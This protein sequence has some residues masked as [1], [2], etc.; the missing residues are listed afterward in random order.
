M[1]SGFGRIE[2][3][4]AKHSSK[5]FAKLQFHKSQKTFPLYDRKGKASG[6]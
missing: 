6:F 5:G 2:T 4:K 3:F 1:L